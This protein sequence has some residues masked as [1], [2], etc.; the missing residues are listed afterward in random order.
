MAHLG[1]DNGNGARIAIGELNAQ[2]VS[3]HGQR[4]T[5][6]LMA[7]DDAADPMQATQAAQRRHFGWLPTM[8]SSV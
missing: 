4:V 7:E 6:E 5:L 8:P 1:K 2:G 3:N